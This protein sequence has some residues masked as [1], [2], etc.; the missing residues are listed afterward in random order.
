MNYGPLKHTIKVGSK[1]DNYLKTVN[2]TSRTM[3]SRG[4]VECGEIEMGSWLY[5]IR[6][7]NVV[8]QASGLRYLDLGVLCSIEQLGGK[9]YW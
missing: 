3:S 1:F 8:L 9:Y 2:I 6:P 5:V 4:K 7:N